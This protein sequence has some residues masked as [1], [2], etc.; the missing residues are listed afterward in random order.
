L[1]TAIIR[2]LNYV[3]SEGFLRWCEGEQVILSPANGAD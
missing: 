2:I 1:D 3:T